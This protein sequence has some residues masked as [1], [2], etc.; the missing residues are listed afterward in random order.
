MNN[1]NCFILCSHFFWSTF[2]Q[3]PTAYNLFAQDFTNRNIFDWKI[4]TNWFQSF[5]PI[6]IIIL[7]PIASYIWIFLEKKI[8]IFLP[9]ENLL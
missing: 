6:F 9:L 4:P 8:Y 7:T 5:N 1:F 2:K 3:K